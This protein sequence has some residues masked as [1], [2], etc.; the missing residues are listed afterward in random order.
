MLPPAW[1]ETTPSRTVGASA[2]DTLFMWLPP[3][4]PHNPFSCFIFL[5]GTYCHPIDCTF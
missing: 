3:W 1:A 4:V 2:A 5:Y